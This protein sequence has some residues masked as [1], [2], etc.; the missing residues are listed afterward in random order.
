MLIYVL[1]FAAFTVFDFVLIF[2]LFYYLEWGNPFK[3]K[4]KKDVR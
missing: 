4:E 2:S 1:I 3:K